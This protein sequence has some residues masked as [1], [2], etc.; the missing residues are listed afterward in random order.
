MHQSDAL[1]FF[2]GTTLQQVADSRSSVLIGQVGSILIE[3]QADC[4]SL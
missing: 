1:D 4:V 2:L 3:A